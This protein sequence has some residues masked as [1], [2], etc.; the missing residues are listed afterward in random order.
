MEHAKQASLDAAV[1]IDDLESA[2]SR[3]RARPASTSRPEVCF[4][5]HYD[6][7]SSE[8]AWRAFEQRADCTVFQSFAWLS[9][10]QQHIGARSG[11]RP[12]IVIGRDAEGAIMFLLPLALEGG[13]ARRL[14]WLG[15]DLGDYNAPLL[16]PE[17]TRRIDRACFTQLWQ[18][19]IQRLQSHPDLKHD[20]VYFEK[21]P[22]AVGAQPNPFMHFSVAA[23]PSGAYFTHLTE[24]W[25][26]F[27]AAKRSSATR[28][29]DRT[30]RKRLAE[31]GEIGFV[32][33]DGADEIQRTLDILMV[34]KAQSFARMGV[35]NIFARPGYPEFYRA[36]A[37]DSANRGLAHISRLDVGTSPAAVN[38]G[39][40]FRGCYYHVL[41]SYD[42]GA[43]SKH[44]P[45]AAHLHD[46]MRHAIERGCRVFDFTIGDERYKRDWCDI[47]ITLF[48]H[49][50]IATA[51]GA[52]IAMPLLTKR[53]LKRWVKQ[54]P[55]IWN[56]VKWAREIAASP[57]G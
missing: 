44:G 47:E 14:R 15:S 40:V 24:D 6:L 18:E 42:G 43:A 11:V 19:I 4:S 23:N 16:A 28:R 34:Q 12:V 29:R 30:K 38:L 2:P 55:V 20:L 22:E 45:G 46:L 49:V 33:P 56:A 13:F 1:D 48:D 41:A 21:M 36:V 53:A 26:T 35:A 9:A 27:Y 51:R 31:I 50:G 39:L 57:R 5:I 32:T 10:W 25:E 17:F 54:T 37:V 7:A 3:A 52:L 8:Q